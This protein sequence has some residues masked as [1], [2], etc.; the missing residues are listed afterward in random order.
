MAEELF[1]GFGD[2]KILAERANKDINGNSLELGIS[3][4]QV[5]SIGG[6]PLYGGSGGSGDLPV[7]V[8]G[9]SVLFTE[10]ALG[11]P[12]WVQL[13]QNNASL[14]SQFNGTGFSA[15]RA[16]ADSNGDSIISTYA[17]KSDIVKRPGY[18]A[19]G[20]TLTD[21]TELVISNNTS[22]YLNT[23]HTSLNFIVDIEQDSVANF[24]VTIKSTASADC[25]V[26]V[27]V[28][29]NGIYSSIMNSAAGSTTIEPGRTYQLTCSRD[30]WTLAEF[31]EPAD[32]R[33]ITRIGGR[34]YKVVRI[35]NL[36]WM[37]ENLDYK[38]GGLIQPTL[39]DSATD[40]IANYYGYD[41][42]GS[43][44]PY[45]G[46]GLLY[47]G[48]AA[49][50]LQSHRTELGLGDWRVPT[51][52]DWTTLIT[53]AGGGST[54]TQ[55][56]KS[57]NGWNAG[58]DGGTND[59][60]FSAIGHGGFTAGHTDPVSAFTYMNLGDAATF[61]TSTESSDDMLYNVTLWHNDAPQMSYPAPKYF[62]GA[63][64]LC[65]NA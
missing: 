24:E 26:N 41:G 20:G 45:V 56:L 22:Y 47:N 53:N 17:K 58:Y 59:L 43:E 23:A 31:E 33:L 7:A 49:M 42:N 27:M 46:N 12:S 50:Y 25:T 5:V 14:W 2:Q 34:T 19:D 52:S 6:F 51:L 8:S 48:I 64:R 13:S 3:S 1:S 63:L 28:G 54:A 16:D 40:P 4:N 62:G 61:L 55:A 60:G 38:W 57:S 39:D 15:E 11:L 36:Y 35:G 37:A 10:E 32:T 65:M 18:I 9:T 29:K 30:G 44:Q 21:N